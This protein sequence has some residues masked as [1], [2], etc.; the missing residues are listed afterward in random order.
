MYL[1]MAFKSYIAH[2]NLGTKCRISLNKTYLFRLLIFNKRNLSTEIL[3]YVIEPVLLL[4]LYKKAIKTLGYFLYLHCLW[5][6]LS[7]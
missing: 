3:L 5:L 2:H 4:E 7:V 1:D 6:K